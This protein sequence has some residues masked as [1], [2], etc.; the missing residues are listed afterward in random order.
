MKADDNDDL[1]LYDYTRNEL[2]PAL[3]Q[4]VTHRRSVRAFFDR[5]IPRAT[6]ERPVSYPRHT[7]GARR[8]RRS[9]NG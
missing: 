2:W 6:V 4:T 1:Y 8:P 7:P 5:P 3:R 9:R